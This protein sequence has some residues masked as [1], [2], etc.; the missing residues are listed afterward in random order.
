MADRGYGPPFDINFMSA[1]EN[2]VFFLVFMLQVMIDNDPESLSVL[3]LDEPDLH[4]ANPVRL[5]FFKFLFETIGN[6]AQLTLCTHSP[7]ALDA[8]RSLKISNRK[9]VQILYRRFIDDDA[10]R[11][12]LESRYDIRY[13]SR[14]SMLSGNNF[15]S[16]LRMRRRALWAH[17]QAV[18]SWRLPQT[19]GPD[20]LSVLLAVATILL[21][22]LLILTVIVS[23]LNDMYNL[24][25]GEFRRVRH[26]W[27]FELPI[28]Q[29]NW[30]ARNLLAN[31]SIDTVHDAVTM[32]FI[33]SMIALAVG[34]V[35][36]FG[37][38]ISRARRRKRL[39]ERHD[40]RDNRQT[41]RKDPRWWRRKK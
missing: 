31:N 28:E 33:G 7:T 10:A 34:I 38:V 36:L 29:D 18:W 32:A 4:I 26:F 15:A 6:R 1:G 17:C 35:L 39:L 5:S 22:F 12:R 16:R 25:A 3:L 21:V 37:S 27:V 8:M 14:L 23:V 40:A 30:V 20:K 9:S 24:P 13:L 19:G 41:G 11:T 2:E